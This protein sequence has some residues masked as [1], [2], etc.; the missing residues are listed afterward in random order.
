MEMKEEMQR[1][2]NAAPIA[3]KAWC[4]QNFA[5]GWH[6]WLGDGIYSRNS[7]S[8]K[9]VALEEPEWRVLWE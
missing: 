1:I 8:F 3:D 5:G 4:K 2:Y 7:S 9:L 6:R